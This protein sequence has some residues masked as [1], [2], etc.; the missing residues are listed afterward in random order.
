VWSPNKKLKSDSAPAEWVLLNQECKQKKIRPSDVNLI[1]QINPVQS[2]MMCR[3]FLA[4]FI[5]SGAFYVFQ[6]LIRQEL[7]KDA[8]QH[9]LCGVIDEWQEIL[10]PKVAMTFLMRVVGWLL[11]LNQEIPNDTFERLVHFRNCL[12]PESC[13]RVKSFSSFWHVYIPR[14]SSIREEEEEEDTLFR[15]LETQDLLDESLKQYKQLSSEEK[16]KPIVVNH[17]SF[18]D[19]LW[20]LL[21]RISHSNAKLDLSVLQLLFEVDEPETLQLY[22]RKYQPSEKALEALYYV[23]FCLSCRRIASSLQ[24]TYKVI[25]GKYVIN[26]LCSFSGAGFNV[27]DS[28][29]FSLLVETQAWQNMIVN[30]TLSEREH[31]FHELLPLSHDHRILPLWISIRRPW[32]VQNMVHS[33]LLC[34]SVPILDY[35]RKSRDTW[36]NP[37]RCMDALTWVA[38]SVSSSDMNNATFFWNGYAILLECLSDQQIEE[39]VLFPKVQSMLENWVSWNPTVSSYWIENQMNRLFRRVVLTT[40]LLHL[41]LQNQHTAL[42]E[43]V[44]SEN[45]Q[46]LPEECSMISFHRIC[47]LHHK[48]LQVYPNPFQSLFLYCTQQTKEVEKKRWDDVRQQHLQHY[49]VTD[50]AA[51]VVSYFYCDWDDFLLLEASKKKE[52][53]CV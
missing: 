3:Q 15:V 2:P 7:W 24:N 39:I 26:D 41:A 19:G 36:L 34:G 51:L 50:V 35:E 27:H 10:Q 47:L 53:K 44:E 37:S 30:R 16:Q 8:Y 1:S 33:F 5:K 4:K 13:K 21:I 32:T 52:Q 29:L 12:L 42:V 46:T 49:L 20:K 31:V 25:T 38:D 11:D 18:N 48:Q 14:N 17:D 28:H 6:Y 22:F 9:V 43:H 23:A 40:R 45:F